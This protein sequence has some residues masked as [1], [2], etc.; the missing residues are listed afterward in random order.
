M[1]TGI[2]PAA[3]LSPAVFAILLSLA[4]GEMTG[5]PAMPK[6]HPLRRWRGK[7]GYLIMKDARAPRGGGVQLGPGTL[8]GS[9]DRMMRDGL[10]EESG[11]SDDER[12][13]YYRLTQLGHS[14]LAVE[15]SRLD[16]AVASARKLGLLPHG[17]RS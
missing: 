7:H 14:V 6:G 11:V 2:A 3:P 5:S 13:R 12:R 17:G 16:A 4:E 8:Y 1:T 10:V 9:L 15:L